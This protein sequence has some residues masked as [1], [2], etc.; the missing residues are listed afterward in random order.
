MHRSY[1]IPLLAKYLQKCQ[2]QA[3]NNF[4]HDTIFN[5]GHT[6][7]DQQITFLNDL[8]F[9][10]ESIFSGWFKRNLNKRSVR[11]INLTPMSIKRIR[12][13]VSVL[14]LS[15][16]SSLDNLKNIS[17]SFFCRLITFQNNDLSQM[18]S[19]ILI[20]K[21]FQCFLNTIANICN[22]K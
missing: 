15:K 6:N 7:I 2:L 8:K 3:G 10:F 11:P 5:F 12:F 17:P 18:K 1:H 16:I 4:L 9:S 22:L 21:R 14:A 19:F 20:D 13:I